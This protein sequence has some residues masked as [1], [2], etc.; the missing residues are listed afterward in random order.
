MLGLILSITPSSLPRHPVHDPGSSH[1]RPS[2]LQRRRGETPLLFCSLLSLL[3]LPFLLTF[4]TTSKTKVSPIASKSRYSS[5][6][7]FLRRND[8]RHPSLL[9]N[10]LFRQVLSSL[11]KKT[12]P[13]FGAFVDGCRGADKRSLGYELRFT[14][15]ASY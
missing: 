6:L 10:Y 13:V 4:V 3:I 12:L 5:T 14:Y 7:L 9:S 15:I 1:S 11:D 8:A 2:K